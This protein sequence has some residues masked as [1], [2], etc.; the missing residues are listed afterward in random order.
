[1][2]E[3]KPIMTTHVSKYFKFLDFYSNIK[4]DN[5]MIKNQN[6]M[7]KETLDSPS[8]LPY[9][10]ST[11]KVPSISSHKHLRKSKI[12]PSQYINWNEND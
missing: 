10:S 8:K 3:S 5:T 2:E 9:C 6:K 7:T 4:T 1:M 11:H 12:L